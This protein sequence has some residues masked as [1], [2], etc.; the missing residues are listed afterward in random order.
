MAPDIESPHGNALRKGRYSQPGGIYLLTSVTEARKPHLENWQLGRLLVAEFR[1]AHEAG[2]CESLAFVVM[3]D[4]FH[5]LI[6]LKEGSLAALMGRVRSRSAIA[7]NRAN[8]TNG[9]LW[10]RGYHDHALR[11]DE[12]LLT[13][14]HYVVANPL[15][16]GLVSRL[17]DYPLWDTM[18]L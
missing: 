10:Q 16:A 8:V 11:K 4:H 6:T 13:A 3:P 15:R 17:G 2:L 14:A 9:Q 5:W 1:Q 18:F 7:V 12:D